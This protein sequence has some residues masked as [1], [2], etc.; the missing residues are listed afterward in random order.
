MNLP[1]RP[2]L[3]TP[4]KSLID[5]LARPWLQSA[6]LYLGLSAVEAGHFVNSGLLQLPGLVIQLQPWRDTPQPQWLA[7]GLL[8]RPNDV[9]PLLW[10]ELLLRSNCAMSAISACAAAI[11]ER[12]HGLLVNRLSMQPYSDTTQ[13]GEALA[14]LI[15]LAESLIAGATALSTGATR[16]E[17]LAEPPSTPVLLA[18]SKAAMAHRWHRSLLVQALQHLGNT[19]PAQSIDSVGVIRIGKQPLEIIA[20]S[21]ERHLLV[22]TAINSPLHSS[23]QRKLALRA[24]LELMTLTG[25]AVALAPQ[26]ACL[27]ARWD[28]KGLDGIALGDWLGDF[29][30]LA[31]AMGT[32]PAP[33]SVTRSRL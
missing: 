10:N 4:V 5:P 15:A 13:L 25:C 33:S 21:D 29:A 2:P 19:T 18:S 17:T 9:S 22:S 31:G 27:Q 24:N 23:S 11:D 26:G 1:F 8:S 14:V 28:S 32:R 7:L 6:A 16:S 30:Q 3:K 20:D 12:G